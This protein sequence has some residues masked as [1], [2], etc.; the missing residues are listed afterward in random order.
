MSRTVVLLGAGASVQPGDSDYE[1]A[2]DRL[3]S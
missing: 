2:M 3:Y 1:E